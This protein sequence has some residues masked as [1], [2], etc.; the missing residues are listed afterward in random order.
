MSLESTVVSFLLNFA[1]AELQ[2]ANKNLEE[3]HATFDKFFAGLRKDLE[4]VEARVNAAKASQS[5]TSEQ[6]QQPPSP[7]GAEDA[8][9]PPPASQQTNGGSL[10]ELKDVKPAKDQELRDRR[11]EYGVAWIV[12]MRFARRAEGV[13]SARAVFGKAR[14]D[15][16]TPW[17]VY[18]A[19]GQFAPAF[20]SSLR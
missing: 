13:K 3:V 20:L 1:Y 16:W 4:V 9:V 15:R 14:K 17:E 5:Q 19:A 18:E 2:E 6:P 7:V 10:L 12:Y 8:F 11:T